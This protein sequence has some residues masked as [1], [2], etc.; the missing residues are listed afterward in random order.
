MTFDFSLRIETFSSHFPV[1]Q[2]LLAFLTNDGC[3]SEQL[4]ALSENEIP[5]RQH[6][7]IPNSRTKNSLTAPNV[8]PTSLTIYL[9]RRLEGYI[10]TRRHFL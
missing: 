6:V 7:C 4:F 5:R 8:T 2:H 10:Y 9:L 3:F 1:Y